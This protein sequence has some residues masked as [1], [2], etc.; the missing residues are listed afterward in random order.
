MA[1][2]KVAV[3]VLGLAVLVAC[4]MPAVASPDGITLGTANGGSTFIGTGST[5]SVNMDFGACA[6]STCTL[7]GVAFGS[8]MFQ[9]N[10][11]YT[12]TS[13]EN[14]D[15]ELTDPT[16]GLWTAN[17][18]ANSISFSYGPGGSLLTGVLN[19]LQFQQIAK[20]K[21]GNNNW[22]LTSADVTI[23][24]GSLDITQGMSLQLFFNK[25]PIY[26]NNLLGSGNAGTT[27]T[28]NF[29]HG[30]MSA[31]PEPT[32]LLL[33][34]IGWLVLGLVLRMRARRTQIVPQL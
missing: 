17:T 15:L 31:T 4:A 6:G 13:P 11:S 34:G 5:D 3:F 1:I 32:S 24:G 7:S 19:L 16:T 14:I 30:T 22:Y 21:S 27:E 8:G 18:Q 33:F 10:G 20:S 9:S 25:V 29:G 23:T 12:I 28:T 26:F 2:R